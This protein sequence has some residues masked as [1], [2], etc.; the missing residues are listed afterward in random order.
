[1]AYSRQKGSGKRTAGER[2]AIAGGRIRPVSVD[3][4]IFNQLLRASRPSL[5]RGGVMR[6]IDRVSGSFLVILF[7][8]VALLCGSLLFATL[9]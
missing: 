3:C 5:K 1:L 4:E 6:S 7:G 2:S 8:G 9:G